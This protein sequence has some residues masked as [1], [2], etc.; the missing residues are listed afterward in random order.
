MLK[1]HDKVDDLLWAAFFEVSREVGCQRSWK[2]VRFK[3]GGDAAR[4][5]VWVVHY[6]VT[7][8]LP[9]GVVRFPG[10]SY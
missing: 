1:G 6:L 5:G 3:Y 8:L 7:C 4:N 9:C 2:V 10:R